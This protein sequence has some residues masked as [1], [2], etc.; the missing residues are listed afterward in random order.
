VTAVRPTQ[1]LARAT[2]V[3]SRQ[4]A[5]PAAPN[6]AQ[7]LTAN[8]P[9]VTGLPM[10]TLFHDHSVSSSQSPCAKDPVAGGDD[11]AFRA[12]DWPAPPDRPPKLR[13]ILSTP[14]DLGKRV[15]STPITFGCTVHLRFHGIPLIAC[16]TRDTERMRTP[17]NECE[18]LRT[19]SMA[20]YW[21]M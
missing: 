17:P 3:T 8:G 21:I 6:P 18:H 14:P 9:V 12:E 1:Q 15:S 19:R 11:R 4:A 20:M 10:V 2:A 13:P 7:A 16:G 5:Y